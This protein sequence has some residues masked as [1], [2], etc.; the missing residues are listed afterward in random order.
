MVGINSQIYSRTGGYQGVSFAIPIDVALNVKDQIVTTGK[1]NRARLGVTVQELNQSLAN[2]FKLDKP[3]GAL[4]SSVV[5]ASAAAKAGLQPGDI[6]LSVNGQSVTRAGDLTSRIGLAT[7][8]D[9]VTFE[10]WRNGKKESLAATLMAADKAATERQADAAAASGGKLG[11][12]VRALTP[13][14]QQG[15]H[16]SGGVLVE[17]A[18]GLAQRS[19][20]QPG[21]IIVS[22]N[23]RPVSSVD[24]LRK[25]VGEKEKSLAVLIHRGD[26]KIFVPVTVG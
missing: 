22:V 21:D 7:P 15:A 25:L 8:G 16:L 12:A 5:P 4:V 13:E 24:D 3:D 14:E 2:S 1:V 11:V 20:I 6:I 19:G 9:K 17:Q 10:V 18:S 23:G 26:A